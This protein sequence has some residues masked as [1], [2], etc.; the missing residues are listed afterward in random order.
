MKNE[1]PTVA[2]TTT[3][4]EESRCSDQQQHSTAPRFPTVGTQT[5]LALARLLNGETITHL[6]HQRVTRSYRLA[7]E[8]HKLRKLGWSIS[9]T[10]RSGHSA[11]PPPRRTRY[12]AYRLDRT[13]IAG[14]IAERCREFVRSVLDHPEASRNRIETESVS[15]AA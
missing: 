12:A 15:A 4:A 7:S 10:L 1:T 5:A 8:V 6:D 11:G 14:V 9:A 2:D 3:G 13:A